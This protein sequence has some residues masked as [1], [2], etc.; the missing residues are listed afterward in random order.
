MRIVTTNVIRAP[1]E[2]VFDFL[3]TPGNWPRW[4]PSSVA[5]TGAADHSLLPGE[6][7]TEQYRVADRCG[8]AVW[9]VR[10]RQAPHR[11]VIDGVTEDGNRAV[12]TYT[13]RPHDGGTAFERELLVA[14][15]PPGVPEAAAGELQRRVEG[16]SA[17]ALS[18]VKALLEEGA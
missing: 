18:R 2:R 8:S 1:V 10:E 6:Q 9:T 14:D 7:V 4:H 16:E 13:L 12:I 3:T 11:W 15:L 17:E 5:V